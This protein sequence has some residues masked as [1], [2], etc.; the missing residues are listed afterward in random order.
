[1]TNTSLIRSGYD[2]IADRYAEKRDQ[3]SS[4]PY[5]EWLN[6]KL[7]ANSLILDL[8]CGAGLPIDR[9]LIDQGHRVIGLDISA[10]M[11]IL[12]RQNVPQGHYELSD[13]ADLTVG[14]YSVDAV[15]CFFAMFHIDRSRHRQLLRSLHSYLMPSGFLLITTGRTDWEGEEDFLG[16]QIAWSHFDQATNRAL[17]EDAGFKIFL[18]DEHR[19]NSCGDKDWHPIFLAQA[20]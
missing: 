13:M 14:E 10:E 18:E 1:M 2:Q 16:A 19:G 3:A 15:V 17:I 8:G 5:L 4:V 9:W 11:L 7:G 20:N 12:A 6:D